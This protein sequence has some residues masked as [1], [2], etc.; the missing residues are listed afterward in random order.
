[1]IIPH[2]PRRRFLSDILFEDDPAHENFETLFAYCRS[3][4]RCECA[5]MHLAGA[6]PPQAAPCSMT[7]QA[8]ASLQS[9]GTGGLDPALF[10]PEP[11]KTHVVCD[12]L[13]DP[14]C[15]FKPIALRSH[16]V[17]F[18][19]CAGLPCG[20]LSGCLCLA[21]REPM[22]PEPEEIEHLRLLAQACADQLDSL[23]PADV[24]RCRNCLFDK[25]D[26]S[27]PFRQS[28]AP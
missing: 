21:S 15:S 11:G 25:L 8:F 17:R 18:C 4:Y 3:R 20:R 5:F 23:S 13:S 1:M 28:P 22:H 7:A 16:N 26:C 27:C 10:M 24:V 6:L 12:A 2:D 19:A 9:I 14:A